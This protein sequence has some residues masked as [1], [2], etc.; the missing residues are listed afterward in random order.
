MAIYNNLGYSPIVLSPEIKI[1]AWIALRDDSATK[2]LHKLK[3]EGFEW[4]FLY[5]LA[6]RHRMVPLLYHAIENNWIGQP[7]D[8][9]LSHISDEARIHWLQAANRSYDQRRLIA[10]FQA[11]KVSLIVL[12]GTPLSYRL[13]GN[14][15]LRYSIDIDLLV[16]PTDREKACSLLLKQGFRPLEMYNSKAGKWYLDHV[17]NK[18]EHIHPVKKTNLELLWRLHQQTTDPPLEFFYSDA[19]RKDQPV[20]NLTPFEEAKDLLAHGGFHGWERMKWLTDIWRVWECY[21]VNWTEWKKEIK[22]SG[23]EPALQSALTLHEWIIPEHPLPKGLIEDI[24]PL[25]RSRSLTNWTI[26][27]IAGSAY[28]PDIENRNRIEDLRSSCVKYFS[29]RPAFLLHKFRFAFL[30]P[31]DIDVLKLPVWAFDLYPLFKPLTLILKLIKRIKNPNYKFQKIVILKE[32]NDNQNI[33]RDGNF[34]IFGMNVSSEIDLPLERSE[35]NGSPDV[36]VRITDQFP[37]HINGMDWSLEI[38]ATGT[39]LLKEDH[40]IYLKPAPT[41]HAGKLRLWLLG[42]TLGAL[43]WRWGWIPLHATSVQFKDRVVM[44]TGPSGV[45]KSTLAAACIAEGAE[46]FTDD[47][48]PVY[49]NDS[50]DPEIPGAGLRRLKLWPDAAKRFKHDATFV[51]LVEKGM[52]K[53][54][55]RPPNIKDKPERVHLLICLEDDPEVKTF[56]RLNKGDALRAI[57]ENLFYINLMPESMQAS[58]MKNIA[59]IAKKIIVMRIKRPGGLDEVEILAKKLASGWPGKEDL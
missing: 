15:A 50:G 7:P 5:E 14:F 10:S 4:E 13:Y 9:L 44:I 33:L 25:V 55:Y 26:K 40:S 11:E 19:K 3:T 8:R 16:H 27:E 51:G 2:Q 28:R 47:I 18:L 35:N 59:E 23:L 41:V 43:C 21:E 32:E 36:T 49:I 58:V 29:L 38:P 48:S 37:I 39:I 52:E 57:T 42:S 53:L 34:R 1:L 24:K 20:Y 31:K 12:K 45:G 30:A 22:D 46:L 17:E 6:K 56:G 54:E